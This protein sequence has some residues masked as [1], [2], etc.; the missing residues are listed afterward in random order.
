MIGKELFVKVIDDMRVQYYSDVKNGDLLK[1]AFQLNEY[2]VFDNSRLYKNIINL[3]SVDFD[4]EEL[5]HYCFE[6]GFG[7][8]SESGEA[9]TSEM[10]YERLTKK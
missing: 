5:N 7:K 9:E 6:L 1:E 2:P 4:A 10:L 8:H 3:L